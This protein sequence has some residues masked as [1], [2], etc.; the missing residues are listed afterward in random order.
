M[1][2][3]S[4]QAPFGFEWEGDVLIPHDSEGETL[5]LIF[6]LFIEHQRKE[7]VARLLNEQ[8]IN[9]RR[10][11]QWSGTQIKRSLESSAAN[12]LH[13]VKT[14]KLDPQ[15]K[16]V[17]RP[18]S[19]WLR[20]ECQRVVNEETWEKVESILHEQ[21]SGRPN[22]TQTVAH[23]FTGLTFCSCGGKMS[24][25]SADSHKYLCDSCERR[26][27]IADLDDTFAS[28]LA[29]YVRE[30]SSTLSKMTGESKVLQEARQ[31][32]TELA[33]KMNQL[34]DKLSRNHDLYLAEHI[35][36]DRFNATQALLE[37]QLADT[38][39]QLGEA[40]H[41]LAQIESDSSTQDGV[42][43]I[44]RFVANWPDLS[45][46]IRRRIVLALIQKLV[47]SDGQI[48]LHYHCQ[49]PRAQ[50]QPPPPH[51]SLD[52][53]TD[54]LKDGTNAPQTPHP[55]N[56]PAPRPA[57]DPVYIRLPKAGER[58]PRTGL[59]RSALNDLI[60]HSERNGFRPPVKSIKRCK[61][62]ATRGIRLIL[63]ESLRAYL[64]SLES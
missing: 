22:S 51:K 42:M 21:S 63:W 11:G 33:S 46:E 62:G 38:Q 48:E 2:K 20:F 50:P 16:R 57:G 59:S 61:P 24:V 55:T 30:R 19:E 41:N 23:L 26:I 14:T 18:E 49:D 35:D 58:C 45:L 7:V 36:L 5:R 1:P 28:E 43:S 12:G 64:A 37:S 56:A 52:H 9:T 34:R 31:A 53:P 39:S 32:Q 4:G 60:L 8:G 6:R 3:R 29:D 54:P 10:G 15:G 25:P 13:V 47:V 17:P 27:A 44:D 40:E